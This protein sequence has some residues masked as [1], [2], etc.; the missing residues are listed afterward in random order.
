MWKAQSRAGRIIRL[1]LKLVPEHAVVPMLHPRLWGMKWAVDSGPHGFWLGVYEPGARRAFQ[2]EV[3]DGDVVYDVG[4]H[5]GFY[6][7]LAS[8]LVGAR[9]H[10]YAFEP[11]PANFSRLKW[12]LVRNRVTNVSAIEAA[13]GSDVGTG[14]FV[15]GTHSSTGSLAHPGSLN[16]IRVSTTSLDAFVEDHPVPA[17]IKMDI[18]GGEVDALRGASHLLGKFRPLLIL[19]LHGEDRARESRHILGKHGYMIRQLSPDTILAAPTLRD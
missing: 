8:R 4:A 16:S 5:A 2:T 14:A 11:D 9:G 17:V 18:E 19:S 3:R 13:I 12:H 7:L 15:R 6:S 10:V 1:P